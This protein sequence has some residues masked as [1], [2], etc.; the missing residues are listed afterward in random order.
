MTKGAAYALRGKVY[1][2][3]KE[4]SKAI[5]D[6]EEIVYNKSNNYGYALHSNY[7]NLFRLYNGARSNEM[8]FAIQSIDGI[9]AGYALNIVGYFGNKATMRLIASNCIVP[10]TKM[11]PRCCN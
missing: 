2:F 9:V 6:F 5:T 4:W 7:E 1:L 8:I 3:N 10:S 11:V